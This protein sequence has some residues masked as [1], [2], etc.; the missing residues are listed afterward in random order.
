RLRGHYFAIA[1]LAFAIATQQLV[2][3][4]DLLGGSSGINTP[5][6]RQVFGLPRDLFFYYLGLLLAAAAIF[7][8]WLIAR[9]KFGYGL[10]AIRENE[11]A[12][13][14]MGVDTT[15]YKL[16]AFV[17]AAVI[18]GVA[19]ALLAY[20]RSGVSPEDDGV[21]QIRNNLLP[22]LIPLI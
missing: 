20:F 16:L 9:N 11:D 3:N 4:L 7:A 8:T 10:Q 17:V 14:A 2:K 22:L 1:T 13:Q 12:A 5:I 6:V 18:T 21:F 15:R 19:G